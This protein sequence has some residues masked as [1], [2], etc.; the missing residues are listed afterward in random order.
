MENL[1]HFHDFINRV[2]SK[3]VNKL[4]LEGLTKAGFLMNLIKIE[5]KFLIL[6]QKLFNKL[7]I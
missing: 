3:D 4:Q 2:N 6:Y 1:N 5:I 7:K